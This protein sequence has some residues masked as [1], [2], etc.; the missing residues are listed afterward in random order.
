MNQTQTQPEVTQM[1][2]VRGLISEFSKD[3]DIVDTVALI[4]GR[5][6]STKGHYGDYMSFLAPY[7]AKPTAL[8]II[9]EALR[10]A[11]GNSEGIAWAVKLLKG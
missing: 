3:K 4:E 11:G 9:S 2:K 6:M 7:Q 10:I 1:D 8:Y 5:M